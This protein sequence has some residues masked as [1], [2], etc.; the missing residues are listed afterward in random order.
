MDHP[1]TTG[2]IVS[3][4]RNTLRRLEQSGA[5]S[6][7]EPALIHLKRRLLLAIA[8]LEVQKTSPAH[9]QRAMTASAPRSGHAQP[10]RTLELQTCTGE[11]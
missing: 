3:I 9:A 7:E 4:L 11:N 10:V 1:F 8:E 5:F 6:R 2:H